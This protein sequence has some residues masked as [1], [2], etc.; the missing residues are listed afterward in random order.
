M[1]RREEERHTSPKRF[2]DIAA[3]KG[4]DSIQVDTSQK[5]VHTNKYKTVDNLFFGFFCDIELINT[6]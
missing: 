5:W 6:I 2:L 4:G 3:V 1:L